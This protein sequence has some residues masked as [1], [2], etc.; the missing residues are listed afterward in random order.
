MVGKVGIVGYVAGKGEPRI[1]LD[2]GADAVYFDNPDLPETRSEMAL[3]LKSRQ[4]VIGVLDVQ[5]K[6]AEAFDDDDIVILQTLADQIALAIE[7]ARLFEDSQLALEELENQYRQDAEHAWRRRLEVGNL[8]F[9]YDRL[10]V[11]AAT[12]ISS[13]EAQISPKGH[14]LQRPII[15]RGQ[16]LGK[17]VLERE[18]DQPDW[19]QDEIEI[20]HSTVH[21]LSLSLEN[22]RLLEELQHQA[23]LEHLVAEFS[24]KLWASS[25]LNTIARTAVQ[26]L[27]RTLNVSD[28]SIELQ[29]YSEDHG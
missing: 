16:I 20:I 11:K 13:L 15:L 24:T 21:Q 3:P 4:K 14:T 29:T 23:E 17:I 8:G 26:E 5:S 1:A 28:A 25:D 22:A 19:T 27:G 6:Q 7:N 18:V 2:V 9:I 12:D 10:G